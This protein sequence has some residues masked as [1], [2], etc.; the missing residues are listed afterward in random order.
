MVA[1]ANYLADLARQL[2]IPAAALSAKPGP[3]FTLLIQ[4]GECPDPVPFSLNKA[5][6][7]E[8]MAKKI[9]QA[10]W[11]MKPCL[12]PK[13]ALAAKLARMSEE[14]PQMPEPTPPQSPPDRSAQAR[15]ASRAVMQ[16]LEQ[17]FDDTAGRYKAGFSDQTI[18]DETGCSVQYVGQLREQFYGPLKAPTEFDRLV[19]EV[20]ELKA[21]ADRLE[22]DAKAA[23]EV[24]R[25]AA[26][27]LERKL[28]SAF[29]KNGWKS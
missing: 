29:T 24:I 6:P 14:E 2:H 4:C 16:W 20:G 19:Q 21:G 9:A 28:E 3:R 26:A 23:A 13:H 25:S 11:T 18:A 17:S 15:A 27:A 22:Q 7:V 10:G 12:C 1:S 5:L 8:P